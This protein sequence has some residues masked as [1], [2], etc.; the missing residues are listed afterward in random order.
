LRVG[1]RV[2]DGSQ[3]GS[4]PLG[5][6]GLITRRSQLYQQRRGEL[7]PCTP[8]ARSAAGDGW[9]RRRT[10]GYACT[11]PTS[12]TTTTTRPTSR[13]CGSSSTATSS[14]RT[15]TGSRHR[16][17]GTPSWAEADGAEDMDLFVPV[18]KLDAHGTPVQA[19]T[20]P[21]RSAIAHPVNV[22]FGGL[23]A[24]EAPPAGSAWAVPAGL[25][26]R[27]PCHSS[28][29]GLRQRLRDELRGARGWLG[30]RAR[31][32]R[33]RDPSDGAALRALGLHGH[34]ARG[35]GRWPVLLL[36][37]LRQGEGVTGVADHA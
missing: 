28:V 33:V 11:T 17:S 18:Q 14:T 6:P 3:P 32:L 37:P 2:T 16:G 34:R 19:F 21:N 15:T 9:R 8:L 7:T 24:C 10:G 23:R 12:G 31:Q 1:P 22:R 27:E 5:L 36:P 35:A 30:A 29:R 4:R 20:I 13:T 25:E 26:R